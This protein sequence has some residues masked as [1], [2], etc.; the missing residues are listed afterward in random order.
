MTGPSMEKLIS[1]LQ[2]F[3]LDVSSP[4][5]DNTI[6]RVPFRGSKDT[7][8]WYTGAVLNNKIY[9]TYGSWD[10]PESHKYTTNGIDTTE[11]NRTWAMLAEVHRQH[12]AEAQRKAAKKAVR[13]LA[14]APDCPADHPYLIKK[15]IKPVKGLK[16]EEKTGAILVPMYDA[17]YEITSL[18]RIFPDGE[19]KMLY[20]GRK[21]KSCFVIN[22]TLP[23]CICEGLATGISI[24]EAT[25]SKVLVAFDVGNLE[26]VA[27][28]AAETYPDL[29]ICADTDHTKDPNAGLTRGKV[30]AAELGV[31]LRYPEGIDGSDFNDLHQE[32]GAEAVAVA[33]N[34]V[35][36]N[37]YQPKALSDPAPPEM[38]SPPGILQDIADYY[39]ATAKHPQPLF[40][41]TT[42]LAVASVVLG[43]NYCTTAENYSSLYFL[44]VAKSATGKEHIVKCSEKILESAGLEYLIGPRGYTS[45]SGVIAALMD[46]P[47]HLC[48]IDEFGRKLEEMKKSDNSNTATAMTQLMELFGRLEGSAKSRSFSITSSAAAKLKDVVI[49]RPAITMVG[50]STPRSLIDNITTRMF[51]DGMINRFIPVISDEPRIATE[52]P[53]RQE[54]PENIKAW[55]KD[56]GASVDI[57]VEFIN[58]PFILQTDTAT[59]AYPEY[60]VQFS[61]ASKQL[62]REYKVVCKDRMESMPEEMDEAPGR[63]VEI[64]IRISMICA[65]ARRDNEISASDINWSIK[66]VDWHYHR[67]M[68]LTKRNLAG[69]D[70]ESNKLEILRALRGLVDPARPGITIRDAMRT[71]PFS[72]FKKIDLEEI[73]NSLINAGL[74]AHVDTQNGK[75]RPR[76]A[77]VAVES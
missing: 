8:G 75:G 46:H 51:Q 15:G 17:D 13:I 48:V 74:V 64:A 69:S 28:I 4:V 2:T 52:I 65:L 58:P 29:I 35:V 49:K 9:C 32:K 31:G 42:A 66:F 43:R 37:L 45:E 30:I 34:K 56:Y 73:L 38:F 71:K 50:I 54:V 16:L 76:M 19:K 24:N 61:E 22:G 57:S 67:F 14:A 59:A 21:K 23:P 33:V 41:V 68:A 26:N 40:A 1:Q 7:R 5:L 25:G 27:R 72:K 70:Y 10:A 20:D 6:H 11:A 47:R 60:I 62:I 3:G 18:Q 55:C 44:C 77:Y 39:N 12:K 63:L 53:E 36:L